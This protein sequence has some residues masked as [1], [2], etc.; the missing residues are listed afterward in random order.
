MN[1]KLYRY[2]IPNNLR[3]T[4]G[5][6]MIDNAEIV[7]INVSDIR[8]FILWYPFL[9]YLTNC[10][11]NRIEKVA[12]DWE[13]YSI[14]FED[15]PFNKTF[16]SYLLNPGRSLIYDNNDYFK[17][18]NFITNGT[19]HI[20]ADTIKKF[21]ENFNKYITIYYDIATNGYKELGE[22][23]HGVI[24]STGEF[25]LMGGRHRSTFCKQLNVSHIRVKILFTHEK[26]VNR[27]I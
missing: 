16:S 8:K 19:D 27:N 20:D 21:E 9:P 13:K 26:F 18:W 24:G 1:F 10:G 3:H 15:E 17:D 22:Y 7:E 23:P 12:G 11:E 25:Y 14:N 6:R 4:V 2:F 5:Q